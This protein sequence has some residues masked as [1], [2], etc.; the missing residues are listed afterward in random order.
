MFYDAIPRNTNATFVFLN[1]KNL[2]KWIFMSHL[3]PL[4]VFYFDKLVPLSHFLHFNNI[5]LHQM[6]TENLSNGEGADMEMGK[7]NF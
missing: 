5:S 3:M 2:T 4:A 6:N 7:I 1:L